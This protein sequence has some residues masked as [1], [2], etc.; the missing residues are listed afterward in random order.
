MRV[1]YMKDDL[2]KNHLK[3]YEGKIHGVFNEENEESSYMSVKVTASND[4]EILVDSIQYISYKH[5]EHIEELPN[6]EM[7]LYPKDQ[8]DVTNLFTFL[9][10]NVKENARK[11]W[12][13]E[14]LDK[15]DKDK[16]MKL[17]KEG[18]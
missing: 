13:N 16:F 14:A 3:G 18:E 7:T 1:G 5:Y 15:R 2:I 12:I 17:T 10:E 6:E 9:Q 8:T 4:P 11:H